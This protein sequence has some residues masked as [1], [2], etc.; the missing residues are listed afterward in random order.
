MSL[1]SKIAT[2][3]A[4][5]KAMKTNLG[6]SETA[7]LDEVVNATASG[8]GGGGAGTPG[9]YKVATIE[10]RDAIAAKEGDTC[11]VHSLDEFNYDGSKI[12]STLV[13]PDEIKVDEA[14]STSASTYLYYGNASS[15]RL[16]FQLTKTS[17]SV[18]DYV[19]MK[20]IARYTSTDGVT[21][22]RATTDTEITYPELKPYTSFNNKLTPFIFMKEVIFEGIFVYKDASWHN[23]DIGITTSPLYVFPNKQVYANDGVIEGNMFSEIDETI[24]PQVYKYYNLLVEYLNNKT[25]FDKYFQNTLDKTIP[26]LDQMNNTVVTSAQYCFSENENIEYA[27]INGFKSSNLTNARY[28]FKNCINLKEVV[29]D[30]FNVSNCTDLAGMFEGCTSLETVDISSFDTSNLVVISSLFAG[31]K[32][33][34]SVNISGI[35]TSKARSFNFMFDGCEKMTSYDLSSFTTVGASGENP[36]LEGGIAYTFRNNKALT[37]LDLSSLVGKSGFANM[38]GSFTGCTSLMKIDLRNMDFT[39]LT[40]YENTFGD[41]ENGYV[42][43]NCLIIVK[44]TTQKNWLSS[45][46]PRL[47][48]VK[49]VA[50]YGA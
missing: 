44:N 13:F 49:T 21:Y 35:D 16:M 42:P 24:N 11:I 12:K 38:N 7:P 4:S 32:N 40:Y 17:Y 39:Y 1:M 23:A 29:L 19:T 47:T 27:N 3:D 50:E 48:N 30:E 20:N 31:C 22:T 18:R 37:E 33:L 43:A 28:M 34:V 41:D 6:V 10:E 36:G 45:K 15:E 8:G 5:I 26:V 9:V 25:N 2:I 46:F 14:I